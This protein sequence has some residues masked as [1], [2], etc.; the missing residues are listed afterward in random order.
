MNAFVLSFAL[1]LRQELRPAGVTVT[2]VASDATDALKFS[3]WT[4]PD[5][6]RELRP[7]AY[8]A[9]FARLSFHALMVGS[10]CAAAPEASWRA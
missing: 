8:A 3:A 1:A 10:S 5:L 9:E 7:D 2:S 4:T 6:A